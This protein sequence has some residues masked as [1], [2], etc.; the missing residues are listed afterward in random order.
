MFNIKIGSLQVSDLDLNTKKI[1]KMKLSYKILVIASVSFCYSCIKEKKDFLANSYVYYADNFESYSQ[2]DGSF[3][4]TEGWSGANL[5]NGNLISIDTIIR[6]SG[7]ASLKCIAA[8]TSSVVSKASV[9]KNNL[10]FTNRSLIY[11]S[12]WY[13]IDSTPLEN[14]FIADFEDQAYISSGPGFR[15]MLIG[16]GELAIER[17]K[18]NKST[19]QQTVSTHKMF[20]TGQWV[21][22]EMEV[23]LSKRNNGYFKIWQDGDLILEH[24]KEASLPKDFIYVT[25]GT[26]GIMHQLEVGISA[27]S[28]S[29]TATLY[30]DDLEI[31]SR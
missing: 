10:G 17:K 31:T 6:H 15:L 5:S 22:V 29:D 24:Y 8:P 4:S 16:N 28:S 30:L 23:L 26:K 25:Q 13:Y 18:M 12:A 21:H 9:L 11:F 20:P 2:V 14:L 19:L 3:Y 7:N 1:T 27:N